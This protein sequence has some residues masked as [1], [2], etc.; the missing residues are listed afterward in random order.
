MPPGEK[1]IEGRGVGKEGSNKD[2]WMSESNETWNEVVEQKSPKSKV[3][4]EESRLD[5]A[6]T[7]EGW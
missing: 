1:W 5:G 2:R 6:I 3:E 4:H 7:E